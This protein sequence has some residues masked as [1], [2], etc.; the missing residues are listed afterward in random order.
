MKRVKPANAYSALSSF[1]ADASELCLEG[2]ASV[3]STS[4]AFNCL[5]GGSD[6]LPCLGRGDPGAVPNGI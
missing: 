3:A 6:Q 4:N 2:F 1:F 5:V